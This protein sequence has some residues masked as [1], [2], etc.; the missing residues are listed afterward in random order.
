MQGKRLYAHAIKFQKHLNDRTNQMDQDF[1]I[2]SNRIHTNNSS[3]Q[4]YANRKE[5]SFRE[6]FNYL[7]GNEEKLI[8][9]YNLKVINLPE[10][11]NK[12][13]NPIYK[14]IREDNETL[15]KD[16]FVRAMNHLFEV[17]NK[18][19]IT[20]LLSYEEKRMLLS[21]G[22]SKTNSKSQSISF[23]FKVNILIIY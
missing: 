15:T 2:N 12:I 14:E 21:F 9:S 16:E 17:I 13:L 20:K 23:S 5:N 10:N 7:D 22:G 3:T 19:K 1:H 4:M 8:S 11:I 6:M 18:V